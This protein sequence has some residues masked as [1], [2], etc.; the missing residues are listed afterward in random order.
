MTR[1]ERVADGVT[2]YWNQPPAPRRRPKRAAR[3]PV[4]TR[5][6]PVLD[7]HPSP[8]ALR[9]AELVLQRERIAAAVAGNVADAAIRETV[10]A[11][12]IAQGVS[13][14]TVMLTFVG[15]DVADVDAL[16]AVWPHAGPHGRTLLVRALRRHLGRSARQVFETLNTLGI[17]GQAAYALL[18]PSEQP[19]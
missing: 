16:R 3:F 17:Q 15:L 14:V 7:P 12:Q 6:E 10:A 2:V 11:Q 9:A 18:A 13:A 19:R 4:T 8:E 5:V 1:A